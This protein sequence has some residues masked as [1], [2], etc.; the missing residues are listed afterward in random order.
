MSARDAR[1]AAQPGS[2]SATTQV[3]RVQGLL[4][5]AE[6]SQF[7]D[8]RPARAEGRAVGAASRRP[9]LRAARATDDLRRDPARRR[10]RP[11]PV[12]V[13]RDELRGFVARR[14]SDPAVIGAEDDRLPDERRVAARPG[15]D[16]GRR[17][18]ASRA[19]ASSSSRRA[20]T[21]TG[22]S[23]GRA[24]S[25]GPASTSSTAFP[26]SRSTRRRRSSSAARATRSAA[27]ST[28]AP[29]NYHALT[30][31]VYEDFGLF[32]ADEEIAA[33]VADLFNYLTGFGRP[34]RFRKL[35]VAPF[36]LRERLIEEIRPSRRPPRHGKTAR[37]RIKVNALTDHASSTSST[38]RRRQAP[39]STSSRGAS[40]RSGRAS[41][42]SARRSACGACSGA[43]SSTAG[44][45]S[46]RPG[47]KSDDLHRQRRPDA[48]QPRPPARDP[49]A[50]RGRRAS[51]GSR[52]SSTSC[53]PTTRRPGS[54]ARTGR[55]RGSG[56]TKDEATQRQPRRPHAQDATLAAP[57][58][59]GARGE[60]EA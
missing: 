11:P 10:A 12:R 34:Q 55:G 48:A 20:S 51:S 8:A 30:A 5:L 3:Y 2:A 60:P 56:P 43:S 47:T 29:G 35:L 36:G 54:S 7:A 32:T 31:R 6:L 1:A 14:R 42:G 25:S 15:A 23:S 58:A 24:R 57:R 19:S 52:A 53:S 59:R 26:T 9:A 17:R 38:A 50:G 27:T 18:T 13:V 28:S 37:I 45:S 44:S 41:T 49:R 39:R 21:S 33:D 22:T 4:D 46:S 40:A 16:R